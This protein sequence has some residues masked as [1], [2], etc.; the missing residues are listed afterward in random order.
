MYDFHH[1]YIEFKYNSKATLLFTD[2]D[3]LCY[4]VRIED[5]DYSDIKEDSYLFD[6][7]EY[8][9]N[10]FLFTT[11]NKKVFGKNTKD[12]WP[13]RFKGL[14]VFDRKF[15][16]VERKVAKGIAK[17][18]KNMNTA[19]SV[20]SAD[21]NRCPPYIKYEVSNTLSVAL[22]SEQNGLS[23]FDDKPCILSNGCLWSFHKI[24]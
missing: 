6:T 2:T 23:P 16:L 15:T 20:S 18:V 4:N 7:S 19:R 10:Q 11:R 21:N 1:N 17:N 3:S 24:T 14:L 13:N 22:E 12:P 5:I 8:S 9:S